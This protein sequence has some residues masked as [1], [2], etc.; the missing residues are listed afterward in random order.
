VGETVTT[1]HSFKDQ[2]I[3][4]LGEIVG[5]FGYSFEDLHVRPRGVVVEFKRGE[6]LLLIACEE[7]ALHADLVL[8]AQEH[9]RYRVSLNQLLWYRGIKSVVKAVGGSAQLAALA[10]ELEGECGD[11]LRGDLSKRDPR[12][13]FPMND[14]DCGVYLR[15]QRGE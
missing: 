8:R 11:F 3:S 6:D 12:F 13:C 10:Q 14:S 2:C 9:G 7:N 1:E 5:K 4:A 15:A